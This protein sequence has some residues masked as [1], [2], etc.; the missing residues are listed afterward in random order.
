VSLRVYN[1]KK[2]SLRERV[3]SERKS[4]LTEKEFS[5]RE[6]VLSQRKSSLR[7]YKSP[8]ASPSPK[9][10]RERFFFARKS[11]L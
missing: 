10:G 11:S 8:S 2:F 4:S 7:E 5:H 6:R 3:L 1:L 9:T